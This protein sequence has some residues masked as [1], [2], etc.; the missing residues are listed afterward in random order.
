[1]CR[2]LQLLRRFDLPSTANEQD[3]KRAYFQAAKLLHPDVTKRQSSTSFVELSAAYEEA[4]ALLRKQ[5]S[6]EKVFNHKYPQDNFGWRFDDAAVKDAEMKHETDERKTV[7]ELPNIAPL[8]AFLLC[9]G[10]GSVGLWLMS[11]HK[12]VNEVG[13]AD[14]GSPSRSVLPQPST[15]IV[16]KFDR[17]MM[18]DSDPKVSV[19]SYYSSRAR[20]DSNASN[21]L[22]ELEVTR[23][24]ALE[25]QSS[26][27]AKDE[28][29]S[30]VHLESGGEP[31]RDV[32]REITR[33][34]IR[35][36]QEI[37]S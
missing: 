2:L 20:K 25:K 9:F 32:P 31:S 17:H 15:Y 7:N 1:M 23:A 33:L 28:G 18:Y 6:R 30:N 24:K 11:R 4:R 13:A 26:A 27:L 29:E 16:K 14:R 3:L 35:A 22:H 5:Q 12:N 36:S 8:A 37:L 19:S 34:R 10:V 21:W